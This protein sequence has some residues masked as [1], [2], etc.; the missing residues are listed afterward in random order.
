MEAQRV[1]LIWDHFTVGIEFGVH[2]L[3]SRLPPQCSFCCHLIEATKGSTRHL[4]SG[5][6]HFFI[7]SG[8][9]IYALLSQ[10]VEIISQGENKIFFIMP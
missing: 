8:F 4:H 2:L 6:L 9:C 10:N 3:V 1:M 7:A 5:N